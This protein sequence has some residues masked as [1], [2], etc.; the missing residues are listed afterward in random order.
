MALRLNRYAHVR[1]YIPRDLLECIDAN[2][3]DIPFEVDNIKMVWA[4]IMGNTNTLSYQWIL[5]M[6]EDQYVYLIGQHDKG[7]CWYYGSWANYRVADSPE[8]A[9]E[10]AYDGAVDDNNDYTILMRQIA[11]HRQQMALEKESWI[12]INEQ[13]KRLAHIDTVKRSAIFSGEAVTEKIK[14]TTN[15]SGA[16]IKFG[17]DVAKQWVVPSTSSAAAQPNPVT[18]SATLVKPYAPMYKAVE[19]IHLESA[20]LSD[21][22]HAAYTVDP[23]RGVH[24]L[25]HITSDTVMVNENDLLNALTEVLHYIHNMA[26]QSEIDLSL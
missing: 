3:A 7:W 10:Y 13:G 19:N 21:K 8:A 25:L 5:D 2:A 12:R 4:S 26:K 9:A 23:V 18:T 16:Y 22:H 24:L 11:D 15:P 20:A 17:D 14:P 6:G 1:S